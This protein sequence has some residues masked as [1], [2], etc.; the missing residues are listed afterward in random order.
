[1]QSGIIQS[2]SS[3]KERDNDMAKV[4]KRELTEAYECH[5]MFIRSVVSAANASEKA[6]E[7]EI[8]KR[9]GSALLA[10][11]DRPLRATVDADLV[12]RC[13]NAIE[14]SATLISDDFFK[15]A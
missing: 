10:L 5:T 6:R 7:I 13:N 8:I 3:N 1:M 15:A 11:L 12:K 9:T 2:E 4:T 14:R